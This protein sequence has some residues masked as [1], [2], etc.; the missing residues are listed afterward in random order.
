M[1]LVLVTGNSGVGKSTICNLLKSRGEIAVD[2]DW[3]GYNHWVDRVTGE[4]VIDPP[5][6]VPVGWLER[7]GW[8][9]SRPMIEDLAV[10]MTDKAVFVCGAPENEAEV[11]DLF[12]QVICLVIDNETLRERLL[13][14]TTNAFGKHPEEMA[15]ALRENE[16]SETK[17]RAMGAV[18]VDGTRPSTEVV[19]TILA[20]V[21]SR[22]SERQVQPERDG[23]V[24]LT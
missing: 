3:D 13:T 14:R 1:T 10:K 11:L 2:A 19:D 6:P 17:Y 18:V 5:Y 16:D 20:T 24:G 15:A 12:D 7:F 4:V 23:G 21:G 8:Q 22:E 9:M